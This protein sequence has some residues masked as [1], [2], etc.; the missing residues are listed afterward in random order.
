MLIVAQGYGITRP[1]GLPVT[2]DTI[3]DCASMAKSFTAAA[4]ACLVDD[5]ERYPEVTWSTPVS[6]L[7]PDDFVL[8]D[9]YLTQNVTLV[10]MLSHRIGIPR[11]VPRF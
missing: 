1:N 3:F 10:D 6:G 9:P 2:P 11:C 5:N 4:A 8:S 7:L